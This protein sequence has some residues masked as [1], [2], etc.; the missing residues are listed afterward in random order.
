MELLEQLESRVTELLD[1]LDRLAAENV[2]LRAESSAIVA[3]KA[4][5]EEENRKLHDALTQEEH[6][7]VEALKRIDALLR[8]IQ[9]HDSVE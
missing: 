1:R 3:E 8:R 7:R 4:V 6:L 5:L 2:R 9:E